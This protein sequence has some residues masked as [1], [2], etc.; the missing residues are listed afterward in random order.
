MSSRTLEPVAKLDQPRVIATLVS[1]FIADPVERWLYPQPFAYLTEFPAFVAAFASEAFEKATVW[2]LDGFAAVAIWLPPGA[3]ADRDAIVATLSE[4]VSAEKQADT[5]AVLEQMDA[6]HPKE[7]HWYLPWLG[8]DCAHQGAGLG[9]D[10]LRQCLF[11][12]DADHSP[13]FLE[14]PNPR[15]V[16]FYE[17]HGFRVTS[18]SQAGACPPLTSMLRPAQ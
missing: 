8:V 17:R 9:S 11:R 15:T 3:Q 13:A 10:L 1:A 7:P 18:I 4:S 14:T 12:V 6:A 16:P 2:S 5:F